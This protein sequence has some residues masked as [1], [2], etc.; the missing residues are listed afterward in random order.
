MIVLIINELRKLLTRKKTWVVFIGFI[1][2]MG[3]MV[4]DSYVTDKNYKFSN[5]IEGK[6]QISKSNLQGLEQYQKDINLSNDIKDRDREQVK[7]DL[8]KQKEELQAQIKSLEEAIASGK[9]LDWKEEL[10]LNIT[11][12]ENEIEMM[13]KQSSGA[14]KSYIE[15]RKLEL[16]KMKYLLKNNIKPIEEAEFNGY[17]FILRVISNLGSL[18]LVIGVMVFVSDMVSGESTPPTLKF[19]LIQPVSRGKVLL[20]KFIAVTMTAITLIIS[21]ELIYFLFIGLFKSFG[22]G[23]YPVYSGV[24]W[25]FDNNIVLDN[26]AHPLI[27]VEN[28]AQ[29]ITIKEQVIQALGMQVL[30]IV[31][32]C[33]VAFLISTIFKSSMTSMATSVVFVIAAN[34]IIQLVPFVREK[35]QYI[36]IVYCDSTQV[37]SGN[38]ARNL[39]NPYAT[40]MMGIGVLLITTLVC[41]V[42]S[43][44]IFVKK[45]ILI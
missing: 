40:T 42:I 18:F 37:I 29:I 4:F 21:T 32:C 16:N 19:L 17:N 34:I 10:K 22:D 27:M 35:I 9:T 12:T 6:L 31:A 30:A 8:Q 39:N 11:S 3:V 33:A 41:Y 43:H 44:F 5:S 36:F 28:S 13:N 25:M 14:D 38:L 24:K 2:L 20:S 45:D 15:S 26:G 1:L 23:E 7:I